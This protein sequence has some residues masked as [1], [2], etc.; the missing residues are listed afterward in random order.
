VAQL[1]LEATLADL[2]A[3]GVVEGGG[4]QRVGDPLE[5]GGAQ[6]VAVGAEQAA[7][8]LDEPAD[9]VALARPGLAQRTRTAS[10]ASNSSCVASRC[11][12]TSW[13]TAHAA[14]DGLRSFAT[15][16]ASSRRPAPRSSFAKAARSGTKRSSGRP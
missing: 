13:L 9:G 11:V 15:S 4:V 12:R 2:V 7:R 1:A 14:A 6:V 16:A 10:P 5:R 8:G 3:G